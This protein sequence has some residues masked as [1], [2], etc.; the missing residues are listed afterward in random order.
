MFRLVPHLVPICQIS[1]PGSWTINSNTKAFH[2]SDRFHIVS[3]NKIFLYRKQSDM[4]SAKW[5]C[6][7]SMQTWMI[8]CPFASK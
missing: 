6:G 3:D 5:E 4:Y 7:V 2:H 1:G 8:E